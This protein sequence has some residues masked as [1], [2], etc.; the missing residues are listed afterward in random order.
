[1]EGNFSTVGEDRLFHL[2]CDVETR[3]QRES[4]ADNR[5]AV[6]A[7]LHKQVKRS[8]RSHSACGTARSERGRQ[9]GRQ[10]SIDEAVEVEMS[11]TFFEGYA[12]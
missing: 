10:R 11:F 8:G 3:R 12:L 1:M 4:D 6:Q 7:N 5:V 9:A 2:Q